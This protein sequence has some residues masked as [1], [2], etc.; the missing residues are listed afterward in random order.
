M[1]TF[2]SEQLRQPLNLSGSFTGS[3]FGTASWATDA[4][5]AS[6][7][8]N[9]GGGSLSGGI[10]GYIPLWSGSNALTSSFFNQSNTILKTTSASIDIGL[11]LAFDYRT[12]LF[13]DYNS[14]QTGNALV[15]NDYGLETQMTLNGYTQGFQFYNDPNS[16]Y[17]R[18]GDLGN[19]ENG[20][21]LLIDDWNSVTKTQ[22]QN[23][24]IGLQLDFANDSYSLGDIGG[25]GNH[26]ILT[27]DNLGGQIAL[28]GNNSFYGIDISHVLSGRKISVGDFSDI[29][30]STKIVVDDLTQTIE[31]TGSLNAPNITGSLQGTASY[32]ITASYVTSSGVYGPYG[33]D[34]ILS[35]SYAL[36]A[37]YAMNGGGG[38]GTTVFLKS[39]TTANA[40]S[41]VVDYDSI[42]NPANLLV[43]D[44]SVFYVDSTSYYYVLGDLVNSGS[45]VVDGTLK[46]GG[47]LYNVGSITGTGSII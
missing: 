42:F 2:R 7:A 30:N 10:D 18:I 34:S 32:A 11:Q 23:N 6:Y 12:Y 5:T 35:S 17:Y 41:S 31:V 43:Q 19:Y 3:L 28:A 33:A 9:G 16:K 45:I 24:D 38:G 25:V 40:T 1:S 27:I 15:I 14:V 21:I 22:Y 20:S 44:T 8:L 26:N 13:G 46:I 47:T 4:L 37:S 29:N 36:T 39:R